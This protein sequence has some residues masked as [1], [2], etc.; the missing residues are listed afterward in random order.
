MSLRCRK[1]DETG[2]NYIMQNFTIFN[3]END[4][5][6]DEMGGAY[7]TYGGEE[8]FMQGFGGENYRKMLKFQ[9]RI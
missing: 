6:E 2:E 3:L 8:R 1:V 7:S 4:I 5:K 9:H